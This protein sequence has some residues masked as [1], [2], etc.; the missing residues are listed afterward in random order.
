MNCANAKP[1]IRVKPSKNEL[2]VSD[3]YKLQRAGSGHDGIVYKYKDLV[4]KILKYDAITRQKQGS[5][6]YEKALYFM[7]ELELKRITQPI[8]ILFDV[9]GVYTGYA[10][11]YLEDVSEEK[12][13]F[14]MYDLYFGGYKD[15]RLVLGLYREEYYK[16]NTPF[17]NLLEVGILKQNNGITNEWFD[18]FYEKETYKIRELSKDEKTELSE[19]RKQ[20]Q[21]QDTDDEEE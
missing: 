4:L 16:P 9:D 17:Q 11:K 8:D 14:T 10:M 20:M 12:D 3:V 21:R 2:Y 1:R 5:M 19:L 18:C 6:T 15:A 13:D 7:S